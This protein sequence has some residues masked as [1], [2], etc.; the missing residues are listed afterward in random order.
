MHFCWGKTKSLSY[1]NIERGHVRRPAI[2]IFSLRL[3]SIASTVV[4]DQLRELSKSSHHLFGACDSL[5][6]S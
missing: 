6:L 2:P 4:L 3:N 1:R 5:L